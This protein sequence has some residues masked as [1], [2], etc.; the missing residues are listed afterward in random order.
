MNVQD[1]LHS[2]T[3]QSR[4]EPDSGI[5]VAA[6]RGF[7]RAGCHS[8]LGGRRQSCRRPKPSAGRPIESLLKGET[9]Y[10]WQRGIP[11]L[12]E[13]LAR[14]HSRHYRA[15]IFAPKISS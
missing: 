5:I 12:R 2:I 4:N 9:F 11:E 15:R 7:G 6:N 13:A 1:L 14:Y 10:T 3:R 8:A